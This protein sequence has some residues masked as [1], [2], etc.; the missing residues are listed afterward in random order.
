MLPVWGVCVGVSLCLSMSGCMWVCAY[1]CVYVCECWSRRGSFSQS[2]FIEHEM[3]NH[4]PNTN[5]RLQNT[6]VHAHIHTHTD[7]HTHTH[8]QT[9]TDRIIHTHTD[10]HRYTQRQTQ[11]H[12][13]THTQSQTDTHNPKRE[14]DAIWEQYQQKEIH[15]N[16]QRGG[17]DSPFL[18]S[19]K[20]FIF[21]QWEG[22]YFVYVCITAVW[23]WQHVYNLSRVDTP[24]FFTGSRGHGGGSPG[25]RHVRGGY[26]T[27]GILKCPFYI[28]TLFFVSN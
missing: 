24:N 12:R 16:F 3:N 15:P 1:L 28:T 21:S 23:R 9:D 19:S 11:R 25:H 18:R 7:R 13:H 27:P 20:L 22:R 2:T 17:G 14:T 4:T 26:H 8:R 5:K 6:Q 10:T